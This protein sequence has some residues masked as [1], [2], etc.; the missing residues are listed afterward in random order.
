MDS[1][2][3]MGK[4]VSDEFRNEKGWD[5]NAIT[6][7]TPFMT[8][9]ASS[10]RFWIAKKLNEDPGWAGVSHSPLLSDMQCT[11][12]GVWIAPSHH[13]R[14]LRPR[15]RRTQDHGLH[16]PTAFSPRTRP[17]HKARHLRTRR[18]SHHARTRDARASLQGLEGG[19]LCAGQEGTRV[20]YLRTDGTPLV[21]V[22]G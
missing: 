6:P 9:L 8:L 11:D 3:A 12:E 18:R 2:V 13:L 1:R 4:E 17:Q 20:P 14:R 19:R 21:S 16:P 7:G 5:Q 10:L 22:Q 15:R